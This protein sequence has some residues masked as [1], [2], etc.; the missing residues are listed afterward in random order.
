LAWRRGVARRDA[1]ARR[2]HGIQPAHPNIQRC[3][4]RSTS[5]DKGANVV[6]QRDELLVARAA[7]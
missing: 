4:R 2:E 3:L 1:T 6:I 7:A 5:G